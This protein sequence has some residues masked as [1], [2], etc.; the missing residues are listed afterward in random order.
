VNFPK[1]SIVLLLV[2]MFGMGFSGYLTAGVLA[3]N[4]CP[5]NGGCTR[6]LG[7]PSCLYGFTMYTIMLII[8]LLTSAGHVAFA[9]G[10][11]LV[12]L[13]SLIG[14]MFAGSLLVTEFLNHSPLTICA[15]GFAMFTLTF[16]IGAFIWKKE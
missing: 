10:R 6:V 12:L 16:L 4:S 5:L 14:M 3:E 1:T 11:K 2:L 9:T 15:A 8:V 7:L 13:V